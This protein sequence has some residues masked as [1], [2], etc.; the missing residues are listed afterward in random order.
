MHPYEDT[1]IGGKYAIAKTDQLLILLPALHRDRTVWGEQAENFDPDNFNPEAERKR[2]ANAWKPFGNGQRSCIGRQ[3]AMHEAALVLGMVL[4]RFR[5]IDHTR[6]KLTIKETLTMKPDGFRIKVK[7]R[8]DHPAVAAQAAAD[9]AVAATVHQ[10]GLADGP[11]AGMAAHPAVPPHGTPL[12]VL[13]GSNL[14]T[15]EELAGRIAQDGEAYRFAV[16]LAP[17]DDYADRLPIE[18]AVIVTT[19]SYNGTPPDNAARFCEWIAG[20]GLAPDALKG[21]KYTVFGCGNRDWPATFQ[22][23]PRLIDAQLEKHG[24]QR[25][26]LRGEGDARDDFD[27]QF[28]AWYQPLWNTIAAAMPI[29]LKLGDGATRSPLYTVETVQ[30]SD[31]DNPIAE[32]LGARPMRLVVRHELHTK[33]GPNP[34]ERSTRHLEFEVP[35]GGSY[36]AGDHFGVM[37]HNGEELVRRVARRFGFEGDV[38]VRLRKTASRKTALP[39]DQPVAVFTLLRDY[40]ELQKAATRS[41]IETLAAYTE[42]SPEKARLKALVAD[43]AYRSQILAKRVAVIDLLEQAPACALP[44]GVFLEMM[45]PLAPRYYSISSSPLVDPRR[46]SLT[47]A[48]V[49][50]SARS[51]HG[52]YHGVCSNYLASLKEGDSVR[53]FVKDNGSG[54]RPPADSSVPMIMIGPGTGI[55]PFRG[56]LQERSALKASGQKVGPSMLFFG[57]R[58]PDQDFIYADELHRFAGEGITELVCTFSRIDSQCKVYVQERVREHQD[59]VWKLIEAGAVIYV[60]GDASGM[61]PAQRQAFAEIYATKTG[62]N[63]QAAENWIQQMTADHRYLVDVWSAT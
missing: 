17:L 24:A 23:I 5:L 28:Q 8:A 34:S 32:S 41:Q 15:A 26:S 33:D 39:I 54:F 36:R 12:L 35:E 60:C 45:P 59:E 18:G 53:V 52:I 61:A 22:A 51:G 38:M 11:Q 19:A 16:K 9:P 46:L 42:C 50:G 43:E 47:I 1:V 25:I 2:P 21:A 13:Y 20:P 40:L 30:A 49:E 37:P 29:D 6:Y 56:F 31:A 44:F 4:H 7:R 27:G 55:A 58:R 3:F 10:N 62:A 57:C 63:A 14:G 48:V